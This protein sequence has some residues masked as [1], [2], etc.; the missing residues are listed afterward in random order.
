MRRIGIGGGI[1]SG[2]TRIAKAF[3]TFD[4]PVYYA[5]KEAKKIME[6]EQIRSMI[7]GAFDA[8]L[9]IDGK[10][11]KTRMSKL[12]FNDD[13]SRQKI[14]DIVHPAV[15]NDFNRWAKQQDKDIV[16]IEAA[17]LFE[18]GLHKQLDATILVLADEQERIQ[19]IEKRD[20]SNRASVMERIKS[21]QNPDNFINLATFLIY[22]NNKD[23]VIPQILK[24][25]KKLTNNG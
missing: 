22:N 20:H 3:E 17:I 14:N 16:M 8:S 9:F 12:I 15:Y 24:I 2:K 7:I 11:N 1:G 23:E 4:I 19:R 25:Y 6:T 21:Q 18:T 10:L 13:R 5:D